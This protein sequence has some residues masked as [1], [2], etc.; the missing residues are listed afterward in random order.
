MNHLSVNYLWPKFEKICE[1][2]FLAKIPA[3]FKISVGFLST[4]KGFWNFW[5]KYRESALSKLLMTEVSKHLRNF[6]FPKIPP[7]LEVKLDFCPLRKVFEIFGWHI[8]NQL[9]LS[10]LWLKFQEICET[11]FFM[12]Y[13]RFWNLK[14]DFFPVTIFFFTN[15]PKNSTFVSS[16]LH[17][18]KF[19]KKSENIFFSFIHSFIHHSFIPTSSVG[20]LGMDRARSTD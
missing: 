9:S 13:P 12:K 20:S 16:K 11:F 19:A 17:L 8:V 2:F 4:L 7:I 14:L 10:Y 1:I 3:I 6:F 5:P 15:F 18:C